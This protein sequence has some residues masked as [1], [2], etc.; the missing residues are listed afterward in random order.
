MAAEMTQTL[1]D[2]PVSAIRFIGRAVNRV[3]DPQL[4]T[5]RTEFIDNVVLPGMLH[6]AI[7]RSP[8]AHARITRIDVRAAEQLPG[9]VA[10]VTG[11][12]AR[13]TT[14]VMASLPPEWGTYC[15]AA[16]KA[17]FVG[18]P[19]VA[20]AASSRY[21]AEDA[22]ELIDVE[23]EP[24]TAVVEPT[25]ALEPGSPLVFEERGTNVMLQ[26]VLTWGEVDQAFAEADQVFTE[27]F[28]WHRLGANPM[29]T[30]GIISQWDP[31]DGSLTC[32]GSFQAPGHMA[33]GA[34]GMLGL[35]L[36]KVRM[37]GHPHGGSF[38]GKG[39]ARGVGITA[40][41]SRKSGGRPVKWIEDRM[42]YL[43]A[44]GSQS[45]DRFYEVSLAVKKNGTVTGLKVRLVDNMG[46]TGEGFAAFSA[47][48]PLASFTGCYTIASAQYDL[49]LVATNKSPQ[50]PYRGMG[51]PP[52]NWVLEQMMDIAAR[53]VGL[54]PAEIRRR[55]FIAPEQ[56]P[57]TIPSGN[58]YDSGNYAAALNKVLE[59]SAYERLRQEQAAARQQ[60]RCV[61]I[62]VVSTIEP[63]VFDWNSYA[64]VGMP[65]TGVPEGV[66]VSIN[67][68]GKI[69]VRVGFPLEGQGQY[70]IA[71]QVLADY[72]GMEMSDIVVVPQD[73][74]S[75]PPA[76]GPGGSRLGVALTGAILGAADQLR[77]KLI[78]VAARL[79]QTEPAHMEL[80]DG[81]LQIKGVPG[82]EMPLAQV[83]AV[84]LT[85]SDLLP[86]GI[87][88]RPEA[89]YVWTAPGRTQP[90]EQGRAKSYLTAANACH[91]VM[92]EV[93]PETGKVEILKYY[94]A[95]DCG[96][97][98]NP[99]TVE[100]QTQG[101]L[102]QGVGAALLEE[103]V[104]DDDGQLLTSTFMDYLL[105]TIYDVPMAEKAALVTPSPFTPL[106][107]KGVGE[108]AMH[109]T[110]AAIMCAINDALLPLGVRAHEVPATPNRLWKLVQE[111]K[112]KT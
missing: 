18:E 97:R 50:S 100:G 101:S 71:T 94:I 104:Y 52:H 29:E 31:V 85:R 86:P 45:W 90:D 9:V 11:E 54:D 72:F 19:V 32:R 73:T 106:G 28:R 49:R 79:M 108:G 107:A 59:M 44:G 64:I 47:A 23:Y 78:K 65:M 80:M 91:V 57:Y 1:S 30:C 20:V 48:K 83:A 63:G 43:V 2:L 16:E 84:M 38:G 4:L 77:D 60:G 75:G 40:L 112:R 34:A 39:G 22:L 74:L 36:H 81:K 87:D 95:D 105:P 56:F 61:G 35:P 21:V 26:R 109:T 98:L 33:L 70:T 42:E 3:E 14:Q 102:A 8:Y 53:G 17:R 51:P 58:E 46:A 7:L 67:L 5:G 96:T 93:D 62:G 69:I 12:E 41:L 25:Q 27:Q 111:Q 15:L 76:F 89:T 92:V 110:P 55:N 68:F 82:A 10:V 13:R 37:I 88:P 24:L 99:A 103:Y 6:C 66:T